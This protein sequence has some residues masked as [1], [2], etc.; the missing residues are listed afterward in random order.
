MLLKNSIFY[1]QYL[2]EKIYPYKSIAE[3]CRGYTEDERDY[4]QFGFH[5]KP[6]IYLKLS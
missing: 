1:N 6:C 2:T 5:C 4:F 3:I